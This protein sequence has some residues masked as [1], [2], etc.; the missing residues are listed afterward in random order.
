MTQKELLEIYKIYMKV[1]TVIRSCKTYAQY[2]AAIRYSQLYVKLL[3]SS[4]RTVVSS[5]LKV[6]LK[7][8][9]IKIQFSSK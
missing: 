7:M 6:I 8:Q 2:S 3:P 4:V 5:D 1:I 9:K